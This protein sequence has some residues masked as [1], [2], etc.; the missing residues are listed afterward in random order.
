MA[1]KSLFNSFLNLFVPNSGTRGNRNI[2]ADKAI[3][4]QNEYIAES[5]ADY[6]NTRPP[7]VDIISQLRSNK[8]EVLSAAAYYLSRISH[9]EPSYT[10]EIII[11]LNGLLKQSRVSLENKQI[12]KNLIQNITP[13][14]AE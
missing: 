8:N 10:D 3:S 1:Q 6:I 2:S 4:L 5:E 13:N 14:R 12:I 7:Y 9:N 11:E